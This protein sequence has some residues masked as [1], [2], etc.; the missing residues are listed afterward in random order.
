MGKTKNAGLG[1]LFIQIALAVLFIFTG[2]ALLLNKGFFSANEM[3]SAI[4]KIFSN[5]NVARILEIVLGVLLIVAGVFE[6]CHILG[7]GFGS[8]DD[9]VGLIVLIAYIVVAVLVDVLRLDLGHSGWWIDV[10]R[11]LLIIGG[12]LAVR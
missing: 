4:R 11:D 9:L 6:V 10:A 2:L 3:S 5:G 12:I 8:I 1:I 7:K